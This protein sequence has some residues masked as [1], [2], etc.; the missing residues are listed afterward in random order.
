VLKRSGEKKFRVS[1]VCL[2][3]RRGCDVRKWEDACSEILSSAFP[4]FLENEELKNLRADNLL[5]GEVFPGDVTNDMR[6]APTVGDVFPASIFLQKPEFPIEK[7]FKLRSKVIVDPADS[8][9]QEANHDS[10]LPG[11]NGNI[12]RSYKGCYPDL[13]DPFEK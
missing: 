2:G 12:F 5:P 1:V 10:L 9:V 13:E 3:V 4:R 6:G 7:K 11:F 8:V